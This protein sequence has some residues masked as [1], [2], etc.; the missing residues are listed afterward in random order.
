MD[1]LI[2]EIIKREVTRQSETI[3]LIASENYVSDEI[4][5]VLGSALT[6]KYSEGYPSKRYYPGNANY[7]EIELICQ[8][9][10][11]KL[12]K[13]DPNEW[14]CNV[15][16]L[17]GSPANIAVYIAL[18][19][20][21]DTIMSLDLAAGGHLSHGHK[22]SASGKL[23][24]V[25]N[26]TVN[27]DGIIDYNEVEKIALRERPKI[28]VS[29]FTAYPRIVKFNLFGDAAKSVGAYHLADISHI[30][31]L[32][33]AGFHPSPFPHA[34]V[35]MTTTHKTLRGPRGALI[36][37]RKS[38]SP[39]IDRAVFPGLQGGPHN[40]VTAAKAVMLNEAL[41]D[42]FIKYQGQIIK[43]AFYLSTEL[44][45][46]G[47][48]LS[49]NGTDTHLMLIDVTPLRVDGKL[50]E[51]MLELVNITANRNSLA[52]DEKPLKPSG[53]RLGTPAVTTRG[54]KEPEMKLIAQFLHRLFV[55][56]ESCDTL[57]QDVVWLAKKFNETREQ[58][59]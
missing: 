43:N 15:Q 46:L 29:G 30:A 58:K 50:A 19:Q 5:Q 20:P 41:S 16:P 32:V 24:R 17:S 33:A 31:G 13:L 11:L 12:F 21:S 42:D 1:S 56:K 9:R 35:V 8:E 23:W 36:F 27:Q 3:N 59:V 40:H 49:T 14:S 25:V 45:E 22:V 26:Y 28:I 10:A 57:K 4:L 55:K 52:H 18:L 38:I 7:D 39:L 34:D 48:K 37:S 44:T 53:I 54:M 47:F 51:Q 6:N 2:Q